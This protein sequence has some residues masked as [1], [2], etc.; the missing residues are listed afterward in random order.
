[1]SCQRSDMFE[2]GGRLGR[3]YRLSTS[4]PD[5]LLSRPWRSQPGPA[6]PRSGTSQGWR[7]VHACML[8]CMHAST[9]AL[10]MSCISDPAHHPCLHFSVMHACMCL[11]LSMSPRLNIQM[12]FLTVSHARSLFT[13]TW[14][15]LSF[16]DA[17]YTPREPG[18]RVSWAV[19][20]SYQWCMVGYVCNLILTFL[21]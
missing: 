20:G 9:H 3:F 12:P 19:I 8:A 1:V 13:S 2:Q 16:L 11:F 7:P 18:Y 4:S 6:L 21:K 17:K 5:T 15:Y 10:C 14:A